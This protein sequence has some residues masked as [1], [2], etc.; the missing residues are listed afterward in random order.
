MRRDTKALMCA[1]LGL[2]LCAGARAFVPGTS[3]DH[4]QTIPDRNLF[5]LRAPP[6]ATNEPP[7]PQL[8]KILLTGITTILG[9]KRAL[10]KTLLPPGKPGEQAK[11]QSLILSEGQRE[12]EIEVLAIDETA[13]SVKVNNSGTVMTLTFEKDG[14]KLPGGPPSPGN[15][16]GMPVPANGPSVGAMF[17]PNP[18]MAP[19][20]VNGNSRIRTFPTRNL[21]TPTLP[22]TVSPPNGAGAASSPGGVESPN[23]PTG[24][25]TGQVPAE[26]LPADLTPEEQAIVQELQRQAAEQNSYPP[27]PSGVNLPGVSSSPASPPQ[28]APPVLPQ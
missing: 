3:G 28:A 9:D 22:G 1:L 18:A 10:M 4:Y 25:P 19:G 8:T 15:L 27:L 14:A 23:S 26:A 24:A 11:E 5:G 13:G 20:P 12:G 6:P 17:Q 16:A 21:R 7:P 2:S